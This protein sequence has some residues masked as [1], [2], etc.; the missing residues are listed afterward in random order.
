FSTEVTDAVER[1]PTRLKGRST[2]RVA[3]YSCWC[4]KVMA[5]IG[6]LPETLADRCV[7]IRMQRK[8][9]EE[10]C[11]R[12]RKVETGDLIMRCERFVVEN[13][14]AIAGARPEVPE[15]LNDRAADIWEPLLALADLAGGEWP[16]LARE[17]A[18]ALSAQAQDGSPIGALLFDVF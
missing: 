10:V 1:V 8:R 16:R 13:A 3:R 4:P 2:S 14:A 17:A 9:P 12:L 6:R 15:G 7:V 18:T 5:A 11:E